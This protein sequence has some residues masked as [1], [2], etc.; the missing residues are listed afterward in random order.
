MIFYP[1]LC[2]ELQESAR[3]CLLRDAV[4]PRQLRKWYWDEQRSVPEIARISGI[5]K[6]A[7]YDLMRENGILRRSW[8]ESNYI[9]HRDKPRF[10]LRQ[11]LTAEQKQLFTVGLM[12]YWAEGAKQ[13][14]SVDLANTDSRVILIFLKFLREICGVA[15][16]RL[17]VLLYVYEGQNIGSIRCYW[18][19]LTQIPETQFI[20]PYISK[21]RS[22][23]VRQKVLPYGVVHIRYSDK[24]LLQLILSWINQE[25]DA[26]IS[27]AG[28][29]VANEVRL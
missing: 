23:R 6:H 22:S 11:L 2:N 5:K 14:H 26:L 15:E 25:A 13:G 18:S 28:T 20:K 29:Q 19:Q 7:L 21:F 27:G 1:Y 17:R 10:Q 16:S 24:R 4:S 12:L 9:V 3:G 8:S